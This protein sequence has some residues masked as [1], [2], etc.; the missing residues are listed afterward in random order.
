MHDVAPS[1]WADCQQVL[2]AIREVADIPITLLVVPAY[3]GMCSALPDFE[4]AMDQQ[5]AAGHE[6]ALHGYYHK[7][8]GVPST[9]ID[10]IRR[11]IYTAGEGEF[12]ALPEAEAAERLTLGARWFAANHWPLSGFVSPAWLLG[13]PALRAVLARSELLYTSTLTRL[14]VLRNATG[15]AEARVISAPCLTYS[16]RSVWRRPAS[17]AW[18][19]LLSAA[20]QNA[21]VLRLGLHPR[22]AQVRAL[23]LSWQRLLERLLKRRVAVT[24]VQFVRSWMTQ[25]ATVPALHER[26]IQ[27]TRH[28]DC[29]T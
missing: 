23:R 1:T 18:N 17:M 9:V 20:T 12:W 13:Q 8:P 5:L 24:K 7:D 27:A 11:R 16:V 4:R 2:A 29:S 28:M 21:P 26:A 25:Q 22:D 19:R 6:L 15:A 10:W 3:H 14:L